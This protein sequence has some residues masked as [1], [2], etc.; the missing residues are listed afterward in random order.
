[1]SDNPE[2]ASLTRWLGEL[3]REVR[4]LSTGN[5]LNQ[6]AVQAPDG[7]YVPLASLAFGQVGWVWTQDQL[8]SA[9]S[10]AA[11][12]GTEV[13][14]GSQT[15]GWILAQSP[16]GGV[17][18]TTPFVDVLITGGRARVDL[19]NVASVS[20]SIQTRLIMGYNI[21]GPAPDQ[22]GLAA[23]PEAR[24]PDR[25]RAV[26]TGSTYGDVTGSTFDYVTGLAPGWYRFALRY[27]FQWFPE[28]GPPGALVSAPRIAVAPY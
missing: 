23:A 12:D 24:A 26:V 8:D 20:G 13:G 11:F 7:R 18:P 9:A 2:L 1:M 25:S 17:V 16:D 27:M 28:Q 19:T 4:G 21:S 15:T 22:A 6:G 5:A 14:T 3:E 10:Q